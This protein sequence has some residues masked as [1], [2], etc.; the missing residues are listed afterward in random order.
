MASAGAAE[1]PKTALELGIMQ[2]SPPADHCR[3]THDNWDRAPFNRWSF[4]RVREVLPT[5]PVRCGRGLARAL[6]RADRDLGTISFETADGRQVTLQDFLDETY[7]DG[8]I[9]LH[10]GAV[11]FERYFNG[12]AADTLHLSQSVA[13]SI[14]GTV[15]GILIGRGVLDPHAPVEEHVPEFAD[16]GYRGATLAQVMDMRSGVRFSEVYTDPDSD[17]GKVD[18]ASGWKPRRNASDPEHMFEV[19]LGLAQ[20]REHGG[21]FE[22]RSIETDVMAFCMERVT[23]TR[24][25][26]LVG[27]ELWSKLGAEED[28]NFTV[29]PAGYAQADGGFNATLRDY[30]RFG[31]L[32]LDGGIV[33]GVQVV[34]AD[35]VEAC[36]QGDPSVFGAPYTDVLPA[37]AYTQQFWV[38]DA[39][40]RAYMARGVFGQL[41][42]IDPDNEMVTVKLSSWPDFQNVAFTVNTLRAIHAVGRELTSGA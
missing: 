39:G 17:I 42:H 13:K 3:V 14:A 9:L 37:G 40:T 20:E 15:A 28:A 22:Y 7:T 12:M 19:I 2:G 5:V 4:Q 41:I 29:D 30:A 36:G 18:V 38:E 6:K 1:R 23:G 11:V 34:P 32:H 21:R 8:I 16:C 33:D 26:D 10:R 31:Q 25:A 27:T 35:W 24:L